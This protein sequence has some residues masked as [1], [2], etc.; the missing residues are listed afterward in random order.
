M[1][2][3]K[4]GTA[5]VVPFPPDS[6]MALK[7]RMAAFP[8]SRD[9]IGLWLDSFNAWVELWNRHEIRPDLPWQPE[10]LDARFIHCGLSHE[11]NRAFSIRNQKHIV[12]LFFRTR[13]YKIWSRE[14][15]FLRCRL[16]MR[17][18]AWAC[19]TVA[20]D[21]TKCRSGT[22]REEKGDRFLVDIRKGFREPK[23]PAR[24]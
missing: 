7:G 22:E 24:G 10:W 2:V 3:E 6:V 5:E 11:S 14:G 19:W 18:I 1:I 15:S 12:H 16:S 23:P 4:E 21:L 13:S 9:S 17:D 20:P 8:A